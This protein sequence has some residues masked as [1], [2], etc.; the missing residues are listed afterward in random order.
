MPEP[1]QKKK[2]WAKKQWRTL[3]CRWRTL[4]CRIRRQL[5]CRATVIAVTGSC[6]KT[7]TV[8]FLGRI[9]SDLD[10][11]RT[12]VLFN[13]QDAMLRT[14]R[15]VNRS[16]RFVIQEAGVDG[17][18]YMETILP[19]LRPNIG[20]VTSIGQDHYRKF[21]TLEATAAEKRKLVEFLPPS[22]FAVL[23][24]DDP[25]VMAMA[26]VTRARV[27]SYGLSEGADVRGSDISSAWPGRLSMTITYRGQSVRIM[28]GL[29]GNLLATSLL[30]AV[31][32]AVAAG[33]ELGHC[34]DSLRSV[35]SFPIRM[36]VHRSSRGAWYILDT[37]KA[38]YWSVGKV[39]DQMKDVVAP[40]KTVVFGSFS[41][42]PGSSSEKYRKKAK[43]ALEV[44]D[45][46]FLV[47][48]NAM[49]IRKMLDSEAYGRLFMMESIQD[50]ARLL[51]ED[52]VPDEVIL[53]KSGKLEHAERLYF[54][55]QSRL[56][57]WKPV[58][59]VVV[60]CEHCKESGLLKGK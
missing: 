46:V 10:E 28:T 26:S 50:A 5:M 53:I 60:S 49:H 11:C 57:C 33:V 31:C 41:D 17:P 2:N 3:K 8:H 27:L 25:H 21:R 55:Q 16:H 35:E 15:G 14:L 7:S 58:C 45:R 38:P 54:S 36:S 4:K 13:C 48:R 51:S 19:V 32:G 23:N 29:F 44:V 20:I 42:T 37:A 6:G 1:P 12:G 59:E 18:G 52:V 47:G 34:T 56:N 40:R 24:A 22:G 39:L 30:A 9:L 43:E